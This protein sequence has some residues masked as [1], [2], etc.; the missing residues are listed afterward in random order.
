[1]H[2]SGPPRPAGSQLPL[3]AA[4]AAEGQL[5]S[6]LNWE[7][8]VLRPA[9]LLGQADAAL[10]HLESALA[11]S[12]HVIGS[13][14]SAAD[15]AVYC[16]LLPLQLQ[17]RLAG[18]VA[19]FMTKLSAL[20][21][22]SSATEAA[23]FGQPPA[24]FVALFEADAA[25]FR[26]RQPKVPIPGRRN[27]LVRLSC[28]HRWAWAWRVKQRPC[29]QCYSHARM[30][31]VPTQHC[32]ARRRLQSPA[33]GTNSHVCS[34][35]CVVPLFC[36]SANMLPPVSRR[37]CL[38]ARSPP[39]KSARPPVCLTANAATHAAPAC[40]PRL[41]ITSALPY[42]N[43]VP[44]LGNIIGCVLSADCYARFCRARGHNC[45]YVCGTDEY[46]TA[47]ETKALEEGLTCAQ[48]CDKYHAIHAD[49][50]RWFDIAFDKFGRT[51]T[52]AQTAICQSIFRDV[53]AAG[54]CVEQGAGLHVVGTS[55]RPMHCAYAQAGA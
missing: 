55:M 9:V 36:L 39:C 46:G 4:P 8:T 27:I 25:T 44:H 13:T 20:A 48:I 18:N 31:T 19:G 6:W 47:T 30:R 7:A 45:I 42:V 14:V 3:A 33:A 38:P 51:P 10:R 37:S 49:I 21:A 35:V 50:Y 11:S 1:M 29:W 34:N 16:T 54:N 28:R 43:N 15:I 5:S 52:R 24:A 2:C 22:V 12:G 26:H 17:G 53:H 40:A 23:L 41:Q 32:D